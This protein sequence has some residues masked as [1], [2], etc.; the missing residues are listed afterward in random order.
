MRAPFLP[1]LASA[2]IAG[3]FALPALAEETRELDS[4]E[5]GHVTLQIAVEGSDLL[6]SLEAPGESI[7]GFEHVA[8]T[9][10]QKAA[11]DAARQTLTDADALFTLPDEAGCSSRSAEVELHQE[12]EHNAFEAT[13]AFT[14]SDMNA[15][16]SLSVSLFTLYPSIEE[17]DV[18][19]ATPAGQGSQELEADAPTLDLPMAS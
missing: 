2:L 9:D 1:V 5:H 8:E 11:V 6:V 12:A 18:D 3:T 16:T 15:L 13:Y 17:I 4:H 10:E 19:Y 7:V 14:C